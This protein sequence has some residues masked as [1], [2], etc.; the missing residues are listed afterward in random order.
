MPTLLKRFNKS[1]DA[2]VKE[3]KAS[4]IFLF[5]ELLLDVVH[6]VG[7]EE[8]AKKRLSLGINHFKYNFLLGLGS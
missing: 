2:F 3:L 4:F 8:L 1:Q 5:N 6:K 7:V